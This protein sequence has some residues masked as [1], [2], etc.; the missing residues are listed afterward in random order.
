VLIGLVL[1][2]TVLGLVWRARNGRIVR[3]TESGTISGNRVTIPNAPTFGSCVTLLQFSTVACAPCATTHSLLSSLALELDDG[4]GQVVH[5]DIDVTARPALA[6]QFNL[7]QSPTT[8]ILDGD[9]VL[10]ARISGAPK[11]SEVR[12]E[13]ERMLCLELV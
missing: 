6:K 9:G 2:A 8:F 12:A 7:L 13:L 11:I 1:L 4:T 5:V 10:Q 3:V